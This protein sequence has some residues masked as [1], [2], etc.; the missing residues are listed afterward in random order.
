MLSDK[1][2]LAVVPARGGSKGVPH[3]N[4]HPLLGR[5]LITYTADLMRRLPF[6]DRAIV[7]TDDAAIGAVAAAEGLE[8]PFLRPA[9]LSGDRVGDW[10]VLYHALVE[11]ERLDRCEY[12]IVLMLQP[13]CPLRTPEHVSLA[14]TTLVEGGWDAVW[15]VSSTD[16]KYHPLKALTIDADGTLGLFDR[17]GSGIVARQQLSPVY[18]RNGAAYAFTRRCLL[19]HRTILGRRA[20]AVVVEGPLLSIDTL[21]DFAAVE[22]VLLNRG[23][24]VA[25]T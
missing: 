10:E 9:D 11:V 22:R 15:T 8:S 19:E 23:A 20:C 16:P 21:D 14:A 5:P 7:S 2:V 18:H 12:A 4:I 24:A 25:A 6:V 13:T 3:K 1:R 17:S